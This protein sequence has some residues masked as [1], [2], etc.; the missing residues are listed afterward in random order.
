M[1]IK[2]SELTHTLLKVIYKIMDLDKEIKYYGID[3]PLTYA[4]I[5]MMEKIKE[6]NDS[7]ISGIANKMG[8]T[9]GAVSQMVKKLEKKEL[10]KKEEDP[11]N[12]SRLILRLTATGEKACNEHERY[13]NTFNERIE[14]ILEDFSEE[15]RNK[16]HDFLKDLLEVTS[17][18]EGII[19]NR[20]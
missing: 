20:D 11:N 8:I 9:R 17:T 14:N 6:N 4:E 3:K 5:H 18:F 15:D 13:H 12:L 7:H 2:K 10:V 1:S 19:K 16:I